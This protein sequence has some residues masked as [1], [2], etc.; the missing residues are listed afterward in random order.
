MKSKEAIRNIILNYTNQIWGTKKVERLDML[1]QI[2][3]STL[4]NELFLMQNQLDDLD[5]TILEKIAKKLTPDRYISIRPA[6]T[7]LYMKP[8]KPVFPVDRDFPFNLEWV[9][10]DFF[11]D[12]KDGMTFHPVEDTI[13]YK[14]SIDHIFY[15]KKLFAVNSDF[16]KSVLMN[17]SSQPIG[18]AVWVGLGIDSE[19]D[20]IEKLNFYVDFEN[21]SEIDELYDVLPY[22]KC[23]FEDKEIPIKRGFSPRRKL[24]QVETDND[25]L[26][27]Y[28]DHFLS[29]DQTLYL[30]DLKQELL[31]KELLEVLDAEKMPA[32][33]PKYWF[34][35][36]FPA[37]FTHDHLS[38]LF[39]TTNAF[40]VSNKRLITRLIIKDNLSTMN[41]LPSEIGEK[42]LDVE[43]V[44]DNWG[45][46]Y[47][48]GLHKDNSEF[49]T[50]Q[51]DATN[52]VFIEDH[53]LI[54]CLQQLQDIIEDERTVF[55]GVDKVQVEETLA[56]LEKE[57]KDKGKA[58]VN[59]RV[60][61]DG[62]D[63]VG[64]IPYETST[65]TKINYWVTF[66]ALIDYV[67]SRKLF[68]ADKGGRL[69]GLLALSLGEVYGAR[70]FTDIQD[71]MSVDRYI[72][73]S[74]DRIVTEHNI[75]TFCESELGRAIEG[76]EIKLEG[77]ISPRPK[78]GVVRVIK[79]SLIPS[80]GHPELLQK[81]GVLKSLKTRLQKR[82]PSDFIYDIEIKEV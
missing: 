61:E 33:H 62:D 30:K 78:E 10:N 24:S 23:Y 31:P 39:I 13:L 54:D 67:P 47:N 32:L 70:E 48:R 6:H 63:K 16:E 15:H 41:I 21:Y 45:R 14:M 37:Y 22:V 74:K 35:I 38:D 36:V 28:D 11:I 50:F 49:G 57:K 18:N 40:P 34:R 44:I 80:V 81:K 7:L 64:I 27:M 69:D 1:I 71:I 56:V 42:L 3:I 82:S 29:V 75:R 55:S 19:I 25:I 4:T 17:A 53:N 77:K 26:D 73:T 20:K 79:L 8:L 52:N 76:V 2:M 66:G 59:D 68:N 58:D 65:V 5:A 12:K 72:F 46:H 9:P 43:S 60:K 51:M